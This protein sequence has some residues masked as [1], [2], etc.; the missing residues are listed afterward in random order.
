MLLEPLS[1][2]I[3]SAIAF[4]IIF[5][6]SLGLGAFWTLGVPLD[7]YIEARL[8]ELYGVDKNTGYWIL[9]FVC[10]VLTGLLSFHKAS[11][12]REYIA[13][14]SWI[15]FAIGIPLGYIALTAVLLAIVFAFTDHSG[16][17]AELYFLCAI[18]LPL[19]FAPAISVIWSAHRNKR[20]T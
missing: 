4:R 10:F 9:L 11:P 12:L 8:P 14:G 19:W 13:K 16:N 20:P 15:S 2:N 5:A 1:L 18:W 17:L 3:M 6:M 7:H